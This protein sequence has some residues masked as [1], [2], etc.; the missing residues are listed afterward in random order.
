MKQTT[1]F[2]HTSSLENFHSST[3]KQATKYSHFSY[4][5]MYTQIQLACR[6]HNNNNNVGRAHA[7]TSEGVLGY[8]VE[9]TKSAKH[10]VAKQINE[11]ARY[12]FLVDIMQSIHDIAL[13]QRGEVQGGL[14]SA[15]ATE[16][17]CDHGS[18]TT[19]WSGSAPTISRGPLHPGQCK[20]EV[21]PCLSSCT[22]FDP[23]RLSD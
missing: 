1:S 5:G 7:R 22:N 9:F 12:D 10:W 14:L 20:R 18:P 21:D 11:P 23:R 19:E 13:K 4:A 2:C 17:Y 6:A 15:R 16:E 3:L 8:C